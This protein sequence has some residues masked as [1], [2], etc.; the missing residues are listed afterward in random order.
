MGAHQLATV[1]VSNFAT[2]S[3]WYARLFGRVPDNH[4]NA[5]CAEWKIARSTRI[6]V[7]PRQAQVDACMLRGTV[8]VG[9][10]VDDLD[11]TLADLRGRQIDAAPPQIATHF[12]RFMPVSDPD[13]NLVTFVKST[14]A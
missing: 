13:G 3:A 10:I 11:Q 2:S 12:V 7:L 6:R 1:A 8:S 9:I 14:V 5:C 4:P